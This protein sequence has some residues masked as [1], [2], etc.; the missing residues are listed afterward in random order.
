MY[1]N[2][3]GPSSDNLEAHVTFVE[4]AGNY[5]YKVLDPDLWSDVGAD[6]GDDDG[7]GDG[8]GDGGSGVA[9]TT[10][11]DLDVSVSGSGG[12]S[13]LRKIDNVISPARHVFWAAD[14]Y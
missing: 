3:D 14:N 7:D 8:D 11:D 1:R 9:S 2:L 5:M 6:D 12:V 10:D 4:K 13:S